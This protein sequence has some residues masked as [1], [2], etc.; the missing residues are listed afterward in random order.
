MSTTVRIDEADKDRLRR[1]Q[2][3]FE[4]MHGRTPTHQE[5]LGKALAFAEQNEAA[6]VEQADWRPF[7]PAEIRKVAKR[8]QGRYGDWSAS[9]I[10]RILYGGGSS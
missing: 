2:Q 9:D 6:F 1:L 10:D 7:T 3:R 5:L 4:T 8:I